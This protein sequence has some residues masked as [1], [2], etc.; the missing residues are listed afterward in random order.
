[1]NPAAKERLL[2]DSVDADER[3]HHRDHAQE[4]DQ[5]DPDRQPDEPPRAPRSRTASFAV[6]G[7]GDE[8]FAAVVAGD[9]RAL[10]GNEYATPA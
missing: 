3:G 4:E 2:L 6:G 8:L 9:L 5:L 7:A 10:H 1:M